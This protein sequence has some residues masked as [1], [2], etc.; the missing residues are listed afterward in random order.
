MQTK[1]ISWKFSEFSASACLI[2]NIHISAIIFAVFY[3]RDL[4]SASRMV[5][6]IMMSDCH[7]GHE[8][9]GISLAKVLIVTMIIMMLK[10]KT[11][12]VHA[13]QGL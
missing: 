9:S 11:M 12:K 13:A 4:L 5:E 6:A 10:I 7:L 3:F 1:Y 8:D 2:N